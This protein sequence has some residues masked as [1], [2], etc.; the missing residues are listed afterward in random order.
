MGSSI[1]DNLQSVGGFLGNAGQSGWWGS[2]GTVLG[3]LAGKMLEGDGGSSSTPSTSYEVPSSEG[4][5][6]G[7]G[8][9]GSSGNYADFG[10]NLQY[11]LEYG[12]Q[13]SQMMWMEQQKYLPKQTQLAL[14]LAKQYGPQQADYMLGMAQQYQP[15]YQKLIEQLTSS[16]RG[17]D[18]ADLQAY[19]PYLQSIRQAAED[20][21]VTAMRQQLL[22]GIGSE[23]A[24]GSQLTP[25]QAR[26]AEQAQR[27][28]E[29]ARGIS[30]GTGSS[31]REA[32]YKALEGQNLLA[33]RQSK[34]SAA[35]GQE[36]A[37][38]P[39]PYQ[40]I[41]GR[42]STAGSAAIQAGTSM[43]TP[44]T[45]GS[46]INSLTYTAPLLGQTMNYSLGMNQAQMGYN[47]EANKLALEK[48]MYE[49]MLSYIPQYMSMLNW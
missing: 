34:A 9:S 26:Q 17:A 23:L 45:A 49:G 12:P 44:T 41:L 27:T 15:E 29:L 18:I 43:T 5:D 47:T 33:Q 28:A 13:L 1:S 22:S 37:A 10:T 42:P 36:Y 35:L 30:G 3:N 6:S 11:L 4:G 24:M 14:D 48:Q 7:G 46:P 8:Y 32:V 21:Q 20:P 16:G 40:A 39:D 31:A 38:S 19:A 25:E 2:T